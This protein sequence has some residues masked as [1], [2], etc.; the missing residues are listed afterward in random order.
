MRKIREKEQREKDDEIE[1]AK[2]R[3][4]QRGRQRER[5]EHGG[6]LN[7]CRIGLQS[8]NI[9]GQSCRE[10]NGK[11]LSVRALSPSPLLY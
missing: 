8:R 10:E 2:E 11:G 3:E 6:A 4:R 5:K 9:E 7:N 1:K